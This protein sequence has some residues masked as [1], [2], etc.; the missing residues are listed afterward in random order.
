MI[1]D[2]K[3]VI[4]LTLF[5]TNEVENVTV[6]KWWDSLVEAGV[7]PDEHHVA[8]TEIHS[9]DGSAVVQEL[10]QGNLMECIVAASKVDTYVH[11]FPMSRYAEVSKELN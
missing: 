11:I 9:E 8:V 4:D 2:N 1:R 10:A 3:K 6:Q 7:D 5:E